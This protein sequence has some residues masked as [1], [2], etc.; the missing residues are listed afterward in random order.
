MKGTKLDPISVLL[1]PQP[2]V[3]IPTIIASSKAMLDLR[4]TIRQ[5]ESSH[6]RFKE[7]VVKVDG[8]NNPILDE[9]KKEQKVKF[10]PRSIRSNNPVRSSDDVKEDSRIVAVMLQTETR[11]REY[12]DRQSDDIE[13]LSGLEITIRQERL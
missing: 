3:F 7:Q 13:V 12:K 5:R 2:A 4:Q 9:N 10:I 8:Q 1:A 11:H 6:S